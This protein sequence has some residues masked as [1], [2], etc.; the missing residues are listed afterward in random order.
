VQAAGNRCGTA[1]SFEPR[2]DAALRFDIVKPDP[3]PA[4]AYLAGLVQEAWRLTKG[5]DF[6]V[7][8]VIA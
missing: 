1:G 2:V 5:M 3:E 8:A 7:E 4:A 6:V